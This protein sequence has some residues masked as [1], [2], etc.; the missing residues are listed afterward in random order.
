MNHFLTRPAEKTAWFSN[1]LLEAR[2]DLVFAWHIAQGC[3]AD[4]KEHEEVPLQLFAEATE[5]LLNAGCKVGFGDPDS[6]G[7]KDLP[8]LNPA[9]ELKARLIAEMW[10]SD[11]EHYEFLV[12]AIRSEVEH[13]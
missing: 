13:K 5:H 4:T 12:F 8:N 7:W 2:R 9:C 6:S 10:L 1:L 11:K 3:F